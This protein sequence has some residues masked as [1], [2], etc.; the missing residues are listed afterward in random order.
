MN[1]R[2]P[3]STAESLMEKRRYREMSTKRPADTTQSKRRYRLPAGTALL[4]P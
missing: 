4:Q 1:E 3:G 2:L